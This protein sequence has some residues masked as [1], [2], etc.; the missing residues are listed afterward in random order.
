MEI[1]DKQ[2]KTYF[3]ASEWGFLGKS[4]LYESIDMEDAIPI[5]KGS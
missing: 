5:Q 1:M 2:E 3:F 4:H